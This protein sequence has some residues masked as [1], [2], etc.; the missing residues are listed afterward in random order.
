MSRSVLIASGKGGVGK[1]TLTAALGQALARSGSPVVI[2]DADLGLRSQDA[3][4]GL[5]NQVVY[6]LIDAVSGDCL[7]DQALLSVPDLPSLRLLPAAQFARAKNLDP[8]KLRL[9]LANLKMAHDFVLIDCPAGIEHGLRNVLNAGADESIL[10]VTPDDIA[11]RDAE[12]VAGIMEAKKLPRPRLVVNRMHPELIAR[13]EMYS[14]QV[15]ADLLDLRLLG[16]MPEDPVILRVL[17][18]HGSLLNYDCEARSAVLRIASRLKGSV[19]PFPAYGSRPL[20]WYRRLF[21]RSP[22]EMIPL[23]DH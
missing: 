11:I 2:V 19:V 6:D 12:R 16:E 3:L 20:R 22:K 10:V 17:L 18:R 9:M 8:K 21:P 15:I 23:D 4:L 5:E 1:S 14:A 13:G 7:P